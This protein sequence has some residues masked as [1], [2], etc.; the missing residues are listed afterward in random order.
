[1]AEVIQ[2]ETRVVTKHEFDRGA[3][4][5]DLFHSLRAQ[6]LMVGARHPSGPKARNTMDSAGIAIVAGQITALFCAGVHDSFTERV[7][8]MMSKSFLGNIKILKEREAKTPGY[9]NNLIFDG[10]E[11]D[12]GRPLQIENVIIKS[13]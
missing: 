8:Q 9:I 1:M 7:G 2:N 12:D 4:L 13:N 5:V 11:S 10:V 6:V 3:Y